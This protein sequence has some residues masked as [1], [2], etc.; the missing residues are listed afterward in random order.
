VTA[1]V[2]QASPGAPRSLL[3]RKLIVLGVGEALGRGL[4]FLAMA[5]LFRTLG[6]EYHGYLEKSL[7]I[8]MFCS[9]GVDLGLG[10]LGTRELARSPGQGAG[11]VG[12]IVSLQLVAAVVLCAGW[13]AYTWLV[14][15]VPVQ[16]ALF[17]G[18][19]FS[20]LFL[21]FSL[22]WVFQARDQSV[23]FAAPRAAR[24]AVFCL[25]AVLLV[26]DPS[27][28]GRLPWAEVGG[29]ATL[30]V[31]C[32]VLFRRG[33]E[34]LALRAPALAP[35]LLRE[36]LP[37]GASNLVWA[38]RM[39]LSHVL[40]AVLAGEAQVGIFGAAHR[41]LMVY[42]GGLD[43]YFTRFFPAMS[44][45]AS[46]GRRELTTLLERSLL[47]CVAPTLL[48]AAAITFLA[49]PVMELLYSKEGAGSDGG[50]L[51]VWLIC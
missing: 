7:A 49:T 6:R 14:P 44:A 20:L 16:R 24:Y 41:I 13:L 21:P 28:L 5:Y 29:V 1:R 32:V 51:L 35:G 22:H 33:G 19:A 34:R 38:L 50:P 2:P 43:V 45:A 39:Y 17:T 47:L 8:L 40:I 23:A 3:S 48:L 37:I 10:I 11:L 26:H 31:L 9:L 27:D 15:M 25:L 18:L 42:Q 36:A 4:T 12:R 46:V 30:A